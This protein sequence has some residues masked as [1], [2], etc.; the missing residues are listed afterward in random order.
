MRLRIALATVAVSLA[1][2][3]AVSGS[4]PRRL[5][6]GC[7]DQVWSIT[8]SGK[9]RQHL[10]FNTIELRHWLVFDL[11]PDR[12]RI[13]FW[14]CTP[15]GETCVDG[16]LFTASL[17]GQHRR[18]IVPHVGVT[19][20]QWSPDG[21]RIL[22]AQNASYCCP[23]PTQLAVV[24]ANGTGLQTVAACAFC[25]LGVWAPDSRH[26]AYVESQDPAAEFVLKVRD[27]DGPTQREVADVGSDRLDLSWSPIGKWISYDGAGGRGGRV[28]RVVRADGSR[29]H[30]VGALAQT[31]TPE[32]WSPNG[33]R[34]A[35][36]GPHGLA[37]ANVDGS[38]QRLLDRYRAIDYPCCGPAW[39]PDGRA[40]AYY[41]P[42]GRQCT[43]GH[44]ALIAPSGG[45]R[46]TLTR[47]TSY[48]DEI[49]WARDGR[50]L[51]YAQP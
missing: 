17:S 37:T 13:V 6:S 10:L 9:Q 40:I 48:I 8:P 32:A 7:C 33:Q 22:F 4:E 18:A 41:H 19:A 50:R 38:H 47:S 45:R 2:F 30:A 20:A 1:A 3:P 49:F 11:S 34:L 42:T 14:A 51:Y 5:G 23:G 24:G 12:R 27:V 16:S 29:N 36:I 43:C 28:L 25:D 35:F 46:R 21:K 44:L 26:V 15:P 39:S 31:A